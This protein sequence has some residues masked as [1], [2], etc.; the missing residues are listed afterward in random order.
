MITGQNHENLLFVIMLENILLPIDSDVAVV[1][2]FA[3]IERFMLS[4]IKKTEFRS[5]WF[6]RV[7]YIPPIINAILLQFLTD[8]R[9]VQNAIQWSKF[10]IRMNLAPETLVVEDYGS[11]WTCLFNIDQSQL[12]KRYFKEL[13]FGATPFEVC[14]ELFKCLFA[15]HQFLLF[16]HFPLTIIVIIHRSDVFWAFC[17]LLSKIKFLQVEKWVVGTELANIGTGRFRIVVDEPLCFLIEFVEVG[18]WG[19]FGDIVDLVLPGRW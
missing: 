5:I 12:P 15:L 17:F 9:F 4:Q 16:L 6:F 1:L 8:F 14:P 3:G 10:E 2:F 13:T 19:I 18:L 7:D 11:I